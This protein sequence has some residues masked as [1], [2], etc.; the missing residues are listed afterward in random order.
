MV[1]RGW[2]F[3]GCRTGKTGDV[4]GPA[5]AAA[6]LE[7][8]VITETPCLQV[9]SPDFKCAFVNGWGGSIGRLM[10]EGR[11]AASKQFSQRRR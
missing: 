8:A 5:K 9:G 7:I 2:G 3:C 4:G 11:K 6:V 1:K 10:L